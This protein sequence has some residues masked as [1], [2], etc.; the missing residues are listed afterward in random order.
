MLLLS[1]IIQVFQVIFFTACTAKFFSIHVTQSYFCQ[2]SRL[3]RDTSCSKTMHTRNQWA[4][5]IKFWLFTACTFMQYKICNYVM[6]LCYIFLSIRLT[7]GCFPGVPAYSGHLVFQDLV[8][9]NQWAGRKRSL[10]FWWCINTFI[11]LLELCHF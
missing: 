8:T 1:K 4:V 7:Q 10:D 2:I 5:N 11:L 6:Q 9:R 3:T